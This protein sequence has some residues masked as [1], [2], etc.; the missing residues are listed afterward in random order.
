[1]HTNLGILIEIS[2]KIKMAKKMSCVTNG[3]LYFSC[4]GYFGYHS[5]GCLSETPFSTFL[6]YIPLRSNLCLLN[7]F[8]LMDT[9]VR[10]FIEFQLGIKIQRKPF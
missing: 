5:K 7:D 4:F 8:T 6:E 1:M 2:V 3:E 9:N 10:W